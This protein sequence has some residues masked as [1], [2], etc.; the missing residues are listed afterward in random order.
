M[1]TLFIAFTIGG[2]VLIGAVVIAGG[3][4]AASQSR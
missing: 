1:A 4:Y 3:L 2:L